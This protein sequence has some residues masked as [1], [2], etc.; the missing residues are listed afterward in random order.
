MAE[1][2]AYDNIDPIGAQ[3]ADYMGALIAS[4]VANT[5][6]QKSSD[7]IFGPGDFLPPWITADKKAQSAEEQIELLARLTVASGGKDLRPKKKRKK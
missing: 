4:T 6:R 3:R 2:M 5:T 7:R 1:W